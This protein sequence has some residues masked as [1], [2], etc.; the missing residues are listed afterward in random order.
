MGLE[1]G[2]GVGVSDIVFWLAVHIY[3]LHF[4]AIAGVVLGHLI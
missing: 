1:D 2:S 3:A 4:S